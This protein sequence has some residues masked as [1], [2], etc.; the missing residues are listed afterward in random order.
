ML[1]WDQNTLREQYPEAAKL[2]HDAK[3]RYEYL[4]LLSMDPEARTEH[5]NKLI[6]ELS[7]TA[8]CTE[9]WFVKKVQGG[10]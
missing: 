9:P 8:A 7:T 6:D 4:I 3:L 10:E 5:Q 2:I 1:F